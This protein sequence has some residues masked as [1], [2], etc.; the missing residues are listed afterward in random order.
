MDIQVTNRSLADLMAD[1]TVDITE[2]PLP[3]DYARFRAGQ[4]RDAMARPWV[5]RSS[6]N[7]KLLGKLSE[8]D[9]KTISSRMAPAACDE[10]IRSGVKSTYTAKPI[11]K[12]DHVGLR[13]AKVVPVKLNL[14]EGEEI[15]SFAG[16]KALSNNDFTALSKRG[17]PDGFRL[18]TL[19]PWRIFNRFGRVKKGYHTYHILWESP[20]KK[21]LYAVVPKPLEGHSHVACDHCRLHDNAIEEEYAEYMDGRP[22]F[23]GLHEMSLG[24]TAVTP[25]S[26]CRVH[27]WYVY[28]GELLEH[29]HVLTL[30]LLVSGDLRDRWGMS[31]MREFL[32]VFQD[33]MEV[34]RQRRDGRRTRTLQLPV[35]A[36]R[37]RGVPL[38][39][40]VSYIDRPPDTNGAQQSHVPND[41]HVNGNP[42]PTNGPVYPSPH[43]GPPEHDSMHVPHSTAPT[44]VPD[45][46]ANGIGVDGTSP[47]AEPPRADGPLP[48][49][50]GYAA[51]ARAG[52]NGHPASQANGS[53]APTPRASN[54]HQQT[55]GTPA[56]AP[57]TDG[58]LGPPPTEPRAM[59]E[60][61][62]NAD[63]GKGKGKDMTGGHRGGQ[64]GERR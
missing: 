10:E 8:E 13:G 41:Q 43:S 18:D 46:R 5:T 61:R 3:I 1:V 16:D 58:L 6:E 52:M 35:D 37:R 48:P 54:P 40:A 49:L 20:D 39:R 42:Q 15:N 45:S 12:S 14:D 50:R 51:A 24:E 36:A 60:N 55:N 31:H 26:L 63:K 29:I 4:G 33:Q 64:N 56:P 22:Q 44:T 27:W 17:L 47:P 62:N 2:I 9:L 34:M 53:G 25:F 59:R 7:R 28:T 30:K 21:G 57:R 11:E 19:Q 38:P 23:D 32:Q